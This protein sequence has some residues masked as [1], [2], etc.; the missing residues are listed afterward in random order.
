[1]RGSVKAVNEGQ[2]VVS[3]S[4]ITTAGTPKTTIKTWSCGRYAFAT[5]RI[6]FSVFNDSHF[7]PKY[8]QPQWSCFKIHNGRCT[9]ALSIAWQSITLPAG[10]PI[11][12]N[13]A[14]FLARCAQVRNPYR[15]VSIVWLLSCACLVAEGWRFNYLFWLITLARDKAQ[16]VP[17]IDSGSAR[18]HTRGCGRLQWSTPQARQGG[19]KTQQQKNQIYVQRFTRFRKSVFVRHKRKVVGGH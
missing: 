5:S 9:F 15:Y 18:G 17:Q 1:M 2:K 7:T 19:G 3:T 4:S 8:K 11:W 6:W 16:A 10:V 12:T 14:S 13:C